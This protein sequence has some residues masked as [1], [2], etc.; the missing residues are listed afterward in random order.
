[1]TSPESKERILKYIEEHDGKKIKQNVV[2]YMNSEVH[3]DLRISRVPTLNIIKELK[4]ENR[5]KV[6]GKRKG[7]S[8]YLSINDK[9]RFNWIDQHLSKIAMNIEKMDEDKPEIT[10][11]L[12]KGGTVSIPSNMFELIGLVGLAYHTSRQIKNESDQRVLND[13]ILQSMVNM[14]IKTIGQFR[15]K[16]G[17]N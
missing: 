5:I 2:D 12:K 11:P 3:E 6:S 8:H 14:G 10:L 7:Q 9:S 13:K 4:S 17:S 15:K 1:L 16:F